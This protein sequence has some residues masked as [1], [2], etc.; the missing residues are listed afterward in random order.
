MELHEMADGYA[1]S[2]GGDTMA[3][4]SV[5]PLYSVVALGG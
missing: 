4:G 2:L 3:L 5:A 1:G